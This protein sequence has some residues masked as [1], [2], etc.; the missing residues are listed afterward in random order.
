VDRDAGIRFGLFEIEIDSDF[1]NEVEP[2]AGL[3]RSVYH[4]PQET[5]VVFFAG[6]SEPFWFFDVDDFIEEAVNEG[7][8]DVH[9]MGLGFP[10]GK[11]GE[12]SSTGRIFRNGSEGLVLVFPP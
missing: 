6:D 1:G 7:G 11:D 9:L 3:F 10:T 4:F 5:D 2:C 8:F 12:K